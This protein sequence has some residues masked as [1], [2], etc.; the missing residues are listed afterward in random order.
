MDERPLEQ[1]VE[2]SQPVDACCLFLNSTLVLPS[3]SRS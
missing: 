3:P 2:K 1:K